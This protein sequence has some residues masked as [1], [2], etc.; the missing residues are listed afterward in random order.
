MIYDELLCSFTCRDWADFFITEWA[1]RLRS[2]LDWSI[3]ST[4]HL[5]LRAF[6]DFL[7]KRKEQVE[8]NCFKIIQ[9]KWYL[10][11]PKLAFPT[12]TVASLVDIC[13]QQ[14]NTYNCG[15]I[16]CLIAEAYALNPAP[17]F[18]FFPAY[19]LVVQPM[20]DASFEPGNEPEGEG[21]SL[22]LLFF[23]LPTISTFALSTFPS[24]TSSWGPC[25][26]SGC[27]SPP[28]HEQSCSSSC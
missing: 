3:F 9:D 21:R 19:T 15:V 1:S 23:P 24:L 16:L 26:P 20:P 4:F 5:A 7:Q 2:V 25:Q 14:E 18:Y 27:C 13:P 17:I 6:Y 28:S 12:W 8:L 10:V 22:A 11:Y